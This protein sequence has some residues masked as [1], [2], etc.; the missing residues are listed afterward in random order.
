MIDQRAPGAPGPDRDLGDPG[1]Q[2]R[3]SGEPAARLEVGDLTESLKVT[4]V[5][6][7]WGEW[8]KFTRW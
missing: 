5:S 8:I 6:A 4:C 3:T 1:A 2:R 7:T